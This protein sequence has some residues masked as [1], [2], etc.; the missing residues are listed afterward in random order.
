MDCD[1]DGKGDMRHGSGCTHH[2]RQI[3][4]ECHVAC[5]PPTAGREQVLAT[6]RA[7]RHAQAV[8]ERQA[9]ALMVFAVI[10]TISSIWAFSITSG[11]DMAMASPD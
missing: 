1:G 2:C 5:S 10:S 7:E 9:T 8:P 3:V 11:G 6:P 4:I